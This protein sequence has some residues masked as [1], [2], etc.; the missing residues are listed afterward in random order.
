[1][2]VGVQSDAMTVPSPVDRIFL[3]VLWHRV[4]IAAAELAEARVEHLVAHPRPV[5]GVELRFGKGEAVFTIEIAER[6]G[7]R[8]PQIQGWGRRRSAAIAGLRG[9]EKSSH[10][11]SIRLSVGIQFR[12]GMLQ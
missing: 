8:A 3:A 7:R 4:P 12:R 1:M 9:I 6:T 5:D 10:G 11:N 2:E